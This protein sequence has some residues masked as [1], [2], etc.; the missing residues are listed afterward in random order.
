MDTTTTTTKEVIELLDSDDELN[1]ITA[2]S[3]RPSSPPSVIRRKP[4][5]PRQSLGVPQKTLEITNAPRKRALSTSALVNKD[6]AFKKLKSHSEKKVCQ[7]PTRFF[8]LF[9]LS[10]LLIDCLLSSSSRRMLR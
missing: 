3:G 7:P 8:L 2:S 6:D 10:P 4:L 1:V 9:F 5:V